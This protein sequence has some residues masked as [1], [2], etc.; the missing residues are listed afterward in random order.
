MTKNTVGFRIREMRKFHDYSQAQLAIKLGVSRSLISHWESDNRKPSYDEL[1]NIAKLG[2]V[3]MDFLLGTTTVPD[4]EVI[5]PSLHEGKIPILGVA[6]CGEAIEVIEDIIGYIDVPR[7][8]QKDHFA[9]KAKGD[10]MTPRI[11]SGDVM[12]I[13]QCSSVDSGKVAIVKVNGEEATC[14]KIMYNENGITL[15]PLNSNHDI[16]MFSNRD[17]E[18]LPVTIIGE[19]VEIRRKL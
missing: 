15:I 11:E 14:K 12:V 10:S 2:G 6:P 5:V 19:V 4:G 13:R 3:S 16:L 9:L 7:K 18:Q 8:M 1:I 17:I